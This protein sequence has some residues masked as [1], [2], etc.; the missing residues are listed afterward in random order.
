[1]FRMY[2]SNSHKYTHLILALGIVIESL[3]Y[4]YLLLQNILAYMTLACLTIYVKRN[5][6]SYFFAELV[7]VAVPYSV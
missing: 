1:M 7:P 6:L 5:E 2:A 3:Q 4:G